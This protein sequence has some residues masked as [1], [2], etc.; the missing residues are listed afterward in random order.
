MHFYAIF[1]NLKS[2]LLKMTSFTIFYWDLFSHS[3]RT[4]VSCF[5]SELLQF[6]T[7]ERDWVYFAKSFTCV[8]ERVA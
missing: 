1:S 7:T 5:S 8:V 4:V 2:Q 3:K 6:A